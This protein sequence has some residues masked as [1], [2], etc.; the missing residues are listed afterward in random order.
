MSGV[1]VSA[2]LF[3]HPFAIGLAGFVTT[4]LLLWCHAGG[5]IA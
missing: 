1:T 5:A 3:A 4:S 2:R